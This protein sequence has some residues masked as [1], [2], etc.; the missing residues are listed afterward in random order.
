MYPG[1]R[2]N[3]AFALN[4]LYSLLI[5]PVIIDLTGIRRLVIV[6]HSILH[7]LP[8]GA[9]YHQASNKYL[10]DQFELVHCPSAS[11]LSK[12]KR[13]TNYELRIT[14][15]I[16]RGFEPPPILELRIDELRID[17]IHPLLIQRICKTSEAPVVRRSGSSEGG[18]CDE[19]S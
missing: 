10:I 4:S 2:E 9:L 19:N 15:L 14:N 3:V 18:F 5:A 7:Y 6:P 13:I 17:R 16:G 1:S 8:F 11:I 12:L